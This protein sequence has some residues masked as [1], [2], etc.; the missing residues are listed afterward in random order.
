MRT[1]NRLATQASA[2]PVSRLMSI[3]E[4]W[5]AKRKHR[6]TATPLEL[7]I[8]LVA[9]NCSEERAKSA[10]RLIERWCLNPL[11]ARRLEVDRSRYRL[12]VV[13]SDAEPLDQLVRRLLDGMHRV[14]SERECEIDVLVRHR[15]TGRVWS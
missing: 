3:V 6:A 2:L 4:D 12:S 14:A 9:H 5:E 13:E 11:K 15:S 7:K 1:N 10:H 8:D